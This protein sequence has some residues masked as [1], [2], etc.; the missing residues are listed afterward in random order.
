MKSEISYKNF[1]IRGKS[2]QP[3]HSSGWI[4]R[5]VL[6]AEKADADAAPVWHDRLDKVF[7]SEN[8]ADEFAVQEA[9]SWIDNRGSAAIDVALPATMTGGFYVANKSTA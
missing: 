9:K 6:H 3:T 1:R 2:C 4:P 8:A 7:D 5:Y